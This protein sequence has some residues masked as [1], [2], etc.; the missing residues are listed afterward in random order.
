M[1]NSPSDVTFTRDLIGPRLASW[2]A[3]LERMDMV[4]LTQVIDEFHRN[5]HENEIL[6]MKFMLML[7]SSRSDVPIE[8]K[9][10]ENEDSIKDQGLRVGRTYQFAFGRTWSSLQNKP[11]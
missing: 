6:W 9:K 3:L 7:C 11:P 10:M 8:K 4:Q 1:E 5:L 2:N